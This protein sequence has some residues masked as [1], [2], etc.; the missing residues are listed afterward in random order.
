MFKFNDGGRSAAGFKGNAGD[1]GVRAVAIATGQDYRAV[2]TDLARLN[3]ARTGKRSARNGL[4]REVVHQY[5]TDL[6]WRWVAT[7]KFGKG[8]TTHL[9]ADE[10]PAGRIITRLSKHYAAM[11]DGVVHDA[12][13]STRD[14]TRCVYGYWTL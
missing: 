5:L 3:K 6:G 9:T 7:M 2:Y 11:I 12:F 14:G 10:L 8:C 13:D 1:C 4:H